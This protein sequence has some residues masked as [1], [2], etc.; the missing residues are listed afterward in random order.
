MFGL[1]F[2][3]VVSGVCFLV[4]AIRKTKNGWKIIKTRRHRRDL[5]PAARHTQMA[6]TKVPPPYQWSVLTPSI[7]CAQSCDVIVILRV[8][9][10]IENFW[11]F[12]KAIFYFFLPTALRLCPLFLQLL[13]VSRGYTY[14]DNFPRK[15]FSSKN[16]KKKPF[17][18]IVF[19][20]NPPLFFIDRI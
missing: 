8:W 2:Y 20:F 7:F 1:Y 3:F 15:L 9:V 11:I 19:Y 10:E 18:K 13:Q 17:Y 12:Q 6:K 4:T 16:L 14:S 5:A